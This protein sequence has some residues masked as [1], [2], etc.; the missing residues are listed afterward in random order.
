MGEIVRR[1]DPPPASPPRR[2]ATPGRSEPRYRVVAE[3]LGTQRK[4]AQVWGET[5][6][7]ERRNSRWEMESDEAAPGGGTDAAPS[8][9]AY[10][11]AGLAL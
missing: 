3:W 10:F 5:A 2:S 4:R 9:L 7:G 1:L 11:S 8:P 6:D